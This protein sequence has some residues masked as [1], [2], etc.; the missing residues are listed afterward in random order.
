ML[1][2]VLSLKKKKEKYENGEPDNWMNTTAVQS[3]FADRMLDIHA[4]A[5]WPDI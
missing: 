1:M 3:S 5:Q 4:I 2:I